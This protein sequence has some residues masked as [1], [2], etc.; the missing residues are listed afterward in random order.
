[1]SKPIAASSPAPVRSY[2]LLDGLLV[3]ADE[4]LKTLFA[5]TSSA[6]SY[7]AEPHPETLT[8]PAE[9]REAVALMRVN[10]AGEV[11]AQA[12]YRGHALASHSGETQA[13]MLEAG[14]EEN[15]HL[16]WCA[17]RIAELDGR[18]S[19]LSPLWYGGSF[20]IGALT[21]LVSDRFSLGFV[22]ETER[23]VVAHLDGHLQRLAPHDARSR[24][25]LEQM[26]S[27][28]QRHGHNAMLAGGAT[29]PRPVRAL[30]QATA[31]VMTAT[32]RWL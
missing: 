2:S 25:I 21:G 17:R 27:D 3:A 19:L 20:A 13:A 29:L 18:T 5:P 14:R 8:T 22:G 16:D 23:Q 24:A 11:S 1:M 32:A 9:R 26:R 10:H 12:L 15:D 30:M 31:S 7:P 4:A 28:E 6:R